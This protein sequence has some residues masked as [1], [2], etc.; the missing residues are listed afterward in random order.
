MKTQIKKTLSLFLAVLMV[1]SCWVWVAPEKAEAGNIELKTEYEVE[2][3][4]WIRDDQGA[5]FNENGYLGYKSVNNN[6][7]G[8]TE[9]E[10]SHTVISSFKN[11]NAAD[12]KPY[13]RKT[14]RTEFTVK[15]TTKDFPTV[16]YAHVEGG[17]TAS[18]GSR[19]RFEFMQ[20]RI[21]G[22]VVYKGAEGWNAG[23]WDMVNAK[24]D[25]VIYPIYT[26]GGD[27][28]T[29]GINGTY[30]WPRPHLYGFI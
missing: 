16:V 7:W 10:V 17:W 15:F 3:D 14:E 6:G 5:T 21:N 4:F 8:G 19:S 29:T 1:L 18:A 11:E 25:P 12:G 23:D 28:G 20:V 2:V 13:Y 24:G 9:T 27:F 22:K 30:S 26:E